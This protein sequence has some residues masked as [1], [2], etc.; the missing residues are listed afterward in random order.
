MFGIDGTVELC[1]ICHGTGTWNRLQDG[2]RTVPARSR[3][4]PSTVECYSDDIGIA[5]A[6][7]RSECGSADTQRAIAIASSHSV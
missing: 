7:L 3:D 1:T 6:M 2:I 4:A 5:S